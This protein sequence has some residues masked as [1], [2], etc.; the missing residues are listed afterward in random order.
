MP[1]SFPL[2]DLNGLVITL[3]SFRD[4]RDIGGCLIQC[5]DLAGELS[6][7]QRG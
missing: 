5:L 4:G 7:A 1:F 2:F 6:E 3:K